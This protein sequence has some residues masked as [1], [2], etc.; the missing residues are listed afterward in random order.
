MNRRM[1][2]HAGWALAWLLA[3]INVSAG[4]VSA[5]GQTPGFQWHAGEGHLFYVVGLALSWLPAPGAQ[6]SWALLNLVMLRGVTKR[7][8]ASLP[9]R[10]SRLWWTGAVVLVCIA[11][12]FSELMAE[13][14][15]AMLSLVGLMICFL[16]RRMAWWAGL[17]LALAMS[18]WALGWM[19]A[20]VMLMA[21][22]VDVVAVA[23]LISAAA[24]LFVW[25]WTGTPIWDCLWQP[26]GDCAL[27]PVCHLV[28][29]QLGLPVWM[30]ALL[31]GMTGAV[32]V[33][34]LWTRRRALAR[35]GAA[36]AQALGATVLLALG[37]CW[38]AGADV[39]LGL[40]TLWALL[41]MAKGRVD[42]VFAQALLGMLVLLWLA[43]RLGSHGPINPFADNSVMLAYSLMLTVSAFCLGMWPLGS[44]STARIQ[45]P[46]WV[47][48][49]DPASDEVS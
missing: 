42:T 44:S 4:L 27:T 10:V 39:V 33:G 9:S 23:M 13:G 2:V 29:E 49:I 35:D 45:A 3:L 30:G 32:F 15:H 6:V 16:Y 11:L 48:A 1:F 41:L 26:L 36:L 7:A 38:H 25:Q 40:F 19:V 8:R 22:F 28:N 17:G 18:S 47:G 20:A 31:A 5:L 14:Q 21:G 43:S 37:L 24:W 34:L 46:R 12:P